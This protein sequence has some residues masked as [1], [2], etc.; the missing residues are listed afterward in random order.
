MS[1]EKP[2]HKD[3]PH[4]AR[5]TE[6]EEKSEPETGQEAVQPTG[7]VSNAIQA[8]E[9]DAREIISSTSS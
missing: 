1:Q 6:H 5:Q 2:Q 7:E 4:K 9:Q 3:L 8:A